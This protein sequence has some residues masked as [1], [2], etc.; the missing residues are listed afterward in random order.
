MGIRFL[1][2]CLAPARSRLLPVF[3]ALALLMTGAIAIA[4]SPS[5]PGG[6]VDD[7][8][9]FEL[10]GNALDDAQIGILAAPGDDW[11]DVYH[12]VTGGTPTAHT[13]AVSFVSD[14]VNSQSDS[15][16]LGTSSKDTQDIT[17]W[18]WTGSKAQAKDDIAHAYAAGYTLTNG[19]TAIYAGMD[20]FDGSGDAT[21]GFWFVQDSS[22]DLCTA[23]GVGSRGANKGCKAAGSFAGKHTDGDLLI[24]S[25]FSTGGAVA[26][27]NVYTWSGSGLVLDVG[28]SNATC[29]LATGQSTLCGAVNST[30][31][32]ATG[33]WSFTD[34]SRKTSFL[35]GEFLEIGVDLTKIFPNGAPC[36][37]TF[38]AETRS[39][40]SPGSSLSDLTNPVSFPQC[41]FNIGK[42][43]DG[44]GTVNANSVDYSW[45]ITA[46]NTGNAPLYDVDVNDTLPDGTKTV[47]HLVQSPNSLAKGASATASVKF[48]ATTS[49]VA[50]PSSV[51]NTLTGGKASTSEGGV[52]NV[53]AVPA[54]GT[55]FDA[56]TC[57][58]KI[59]SVVDVTK[60]CDTNAAGGGTILTTTGCAGTDVC[61][62][63]F[64]KTTV[65]NNG[66]DT[67]TNIQLT[68]TPG[69]TFDAKSYTTTKGKTAV[70]TYS[71][72]TATIDTLAPSDSVAITGH[73]FPTTIDQSGVPG[74]FLFSDKV[75]VT[76][77]TGSLGK[78]PGA[79]TSPLC[80]NLTDLAC[81]TVVMPGTDNVG[82]PI[83]PNGACQ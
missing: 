75:S 38:F 78:D 24:V 27:I 81:A 36:F 76:A 3:A 7:T 8:A 12:S 25:D 14:I 48:S 23:A 77:A 70:V 4:L 31:G 45:T 43:C 73:Y 32:V 2:R 61:V 68:D 49:N 67:L 33:G 69:A 26:T 42:S 58:A 72:G 34:K 6:G 16:F 62:E 13:S 37:S 63:V 29:N 44:P 71:S 64:F 66:N 57:T 56:P 46:T 60:V 51:T 18:T 28:K 82:C 5:S 9:V 83:C 39:S 59:S 35:E 15:S 22:F 20:R 30:D 47:L 10:E 55:T 40:N 19:D 11:Q 74:R 65:T 80:P 1:A 17:Q 50:D 41:S 54:T 52:Q 21:A 53:T 79:L